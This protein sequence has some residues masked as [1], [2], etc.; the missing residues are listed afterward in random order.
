MPSNSAIAHTYAYEL[1]VAKRWL[2]EFMEDQHPDVDVESTYFKLRAP[3]PDIVLLKEYARYISRSRTGIL[4]EKLSVRTVQHYME[5]L[6]IAL[7][8][9]C[10]FSEPLSHVSQEC[11]NFIATVLTEKEGL[12]TKAHIKAAAH[13]ENSLTSCSSS[14]P[15]STS[16]R[17]QTCDKF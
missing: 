6:I 3:A 12:S 8:R 10:H 4:S 13:S 9:D 17:F 5:M 14:T 7:K 1:K 2:H 11:R 16:P 15:R